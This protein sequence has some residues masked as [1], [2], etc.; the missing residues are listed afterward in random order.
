[1][2]VRYLCGRAAALRRSRV[3]SE[4]P[5]ILDL[6]EQSDVIR[7]NPYF[8]QFRR[9]YLGGTVRR[10]SAI[11]GKNYSSVSEAYFEAVHSVLVRKKDAR[12]AAADLEHQLIR[13]MGLK[14]R[15]P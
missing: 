3:S 8:T 10:P 2:L 13:I 7:A 12:T 9:A 14:A 6:Y 15:R 1:M 4:P 5:A 11:S